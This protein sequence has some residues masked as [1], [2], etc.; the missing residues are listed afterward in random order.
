MLGLPHCLG[1][2]LVA[3]HRLLIMVA[4]LAVEHG[5]QGSQASVGATCGLDIFGSQ[6]LARRL[7]SCGAWA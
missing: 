3:V 5:L 2:S 4:S 7:S 6:T 1:Y